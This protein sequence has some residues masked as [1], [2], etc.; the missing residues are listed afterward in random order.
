[1]SRLANDPDR[2]VRLAVTMNGNLPMSV[3]EQLIDDEE[4]LVARQA[5]VTLDRRNMGK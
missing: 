3:L 4:Q 5:K 1:M 2:Y